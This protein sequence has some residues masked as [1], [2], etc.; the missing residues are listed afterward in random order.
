MTTLKL[1]SALKLVTDRLAHDNIT[2]CLIGA[3]ALGRYGL[4]RFTADIDL[5]IEGRHWPLLSK[6][7]T[8]LGFECFHRG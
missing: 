5:L 7:M 8:E 4:P 2:Y 6:A 1:T 3:L